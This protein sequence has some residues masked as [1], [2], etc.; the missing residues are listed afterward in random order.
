MIIVSFVMNSVL[1]FTPW[2]MDGH[3]KCKPDHKIMKNS[4]W[5]WKPALKMT[6][7][8][9]SEYLATQDKEKAPCCNNLLMTLQQTNLCIKRTICHFIS[10]QNTSLDWAPPCYLKEHWGRLSGSIT[11][12]SWMI[13]EQKKSWMHFSNQTLI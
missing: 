13:S 9:C 1:R 10:K 11:N 12:P 4:C 6:R 7:P 2:F 5:Q 8:K 3:G